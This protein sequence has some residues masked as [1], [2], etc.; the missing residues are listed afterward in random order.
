MKLSHLNLIKIVLATTIVAVMTVGCS[1]AN[2]LN[3]LSPPMT[4]EALLGDRN[5]HALNGGSGG[6]AKKA[7][8]GF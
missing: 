2:S 1:A 7:R 4:P 5:D 8:Q 6:S 3:P